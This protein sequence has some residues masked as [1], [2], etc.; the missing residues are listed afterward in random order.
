ME[1][2][3]EVRVIYEVVHTSFVVALLVE[4]GGLTIIYR[5]AICS[6]ASLIELSVHFLS[7]SREGFI[8]VLNDFLHRKLEHQHPKD[9]ASSAISKA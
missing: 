8:F 1:S 4:A 9:S 3:E 7:G 6:K 5:L 2:S